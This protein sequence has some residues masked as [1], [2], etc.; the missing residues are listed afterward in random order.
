[1][2]SKKDAIKL[3][4]ISIMIC[5]AAVVCTMFLNYA[6]DLFE[7]ETLIDSEYGM[8]FY[9]AQLA[10][11]KVVCTLSGGCLIAAS[12]VMLIFYVKNYINSHKKELGIL[13]ALGYSDIKISKSFWKFGLSALLGAAVGFGIGFALIP[14]MYE[15]QNNDGYLPKTD[16]HF[17]PQL[18]FFIVILPAVIF[19]I[20][21]ILFALIKLKQPVLILLKDNFQ[22]DKNKKSGKARSDKDNDTSFAVD[23]KKATLKSRKTYLFFIIF[24][25]FCFSA[26]TQMSFSMKDLSSEMMGAITLIIGLTLAFTSLILAVSSVVNGNARTIAMMRVFGYSSR[27]C[28]ACVLNGY[29]PFAYIGFVLGTGYQHALLRITVDIFLK[30]IENVPE[31]NF[32]FSSMLISLAA[33]LIF[34]EGI[35]KFYAV[36]IKKTSLKAIMTE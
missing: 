16:M 23:L 15:R 33:F 25:A 19:A 11:V 17:H 30:D 1:M 28:A 2:I 24:A 5:C 34:Y 20:L 7:I 29:R 3:V 6:L 35:M 36:K 14:M 31:Y 9:E 32:S 27:E 21:A 22:Y 4:G 8:I 12:A 10:T 13:K 26:M 18:V